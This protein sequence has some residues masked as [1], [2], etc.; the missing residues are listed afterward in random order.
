MLE[1]FKF[2]TNTGSV[3]LYLQFNALSFKG[4]LEWIKM[5]LEF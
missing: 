1:G 3:D 5:G 2:E 4:E